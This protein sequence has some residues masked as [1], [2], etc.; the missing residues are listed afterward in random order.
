[1]FRQVNATPY[2]KMMIQ[3]HYNYF[4]KNMAVSKKQKH[5]EEVH[6]YIIRFGI[7]LYWFIFWLLNSLDKFFIQPTFFWVGKNQLDQIIASLTAIGIPN[8]NVAFFMLIVTALLEAIAFI[9]FLV[10][11]GYILWN[12]KQESENV[13]FWGIFV[14]LMI[15]SLYT[16]GD[17]MLGNT[18]A[19]L[20]HTLYWISL[21]ISWGAYKYFAK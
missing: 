19:L 20:E 9:I 14:S 5:M 10:A 8:E 17:Q 1:M 7:I 21:I 12:K 6:S 4:K 16:I 2:T 13:F 3:F 18:N 15:F 11:L